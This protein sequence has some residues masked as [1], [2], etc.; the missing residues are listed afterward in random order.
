MKLTRTWIVNGTFNTFYAD[1][2][3]SAQYHARKGMVLGQLHSNLTAQTDNP[4]SKGEWHGLAQVAAH[5]WADHLG[6][7]SDTMSGRFDAISSVLTQ[8]ANDV[9]AYGGAIKTAINDIEEKDLAVPFVVTEALVVTDPNRAIAL[10]NAADPEQMRQTRDRDMR[11]AQAT[12]NDNKTYLQTA[13]TTAVAG[14]K[15]AADG[16]DGDVPANDR[17]NQRVKHSIL[18]GSAGLPS[19]PTE[20]RSVWDSLTTEERDH[21]YDLHHDLGNHGG[22]PFV[23]T[24]DGRGRDYYNRRHLGE[25]LADP[26]LSDDTRHKYQELQAAANGQ[27][28]L[29]GY[30][31]ENGRGAV[32]INN[33]DTAKRVATLVP[34]TGQDLGAINGAMQKSER[35]YWAARDAD[36]DLK[37]SD[38]SVTTWMGY[39]PPMNIPEA[40]STSY[41]HN[42]A[43]ALD[44]FQAGIRASHDD[45][46]AG[47][48]SINTIIG[49]SYGSTLAGAAATD[50]YL[51]ANNFVAVGSPG[52][53]AQHASDLSLAPGA[54]V[55][56][57]RAQN[58]VITWATGLT[59][60]PDPVGDGFGAT[61]F[62]AAPGKH[63]NLFG[64]Q[65]PDWMH[66]TSVDAHSS[67]WDQNNPA[68][69]NL[70]RII[71]GRVDVT[72]P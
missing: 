4:Q 58:D 38:V 61:Q 28:R 52:V 69:D 63:G 54:H 29:L 26:N 68:L 1:L 7:C 23:D 25:I 3:T 57:T 2:N 48:P 18:D 55:F 62:Q 27:G 12:I 30:V 11:N 15:N 46:V 50:G 24:G 5:Q 56:A 34:G 60:G 37:A 72:G 51:D 6:K 20:M 67:Y 10:K 45:V 49:H 22:I 40:A 14:L 66:L 31:D 70:G 21:L 71:A 17:V 33:P 32:S 9:V 19:D 36:P 39:T 65:T 42:G 53:L 64:W 47:G 44:Q 8:F 35:M 43:A 59:L 16:A 41:A 13:V